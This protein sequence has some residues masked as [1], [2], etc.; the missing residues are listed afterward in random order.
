MTRSADGTPACRRISAEKAAF[1]IPRTILAPSCRD[2]EIVLQRIAHHFGER[3]VG[4]LVWPPATDQ[5]R[6]S[7]TPLLS[8]RLGEA[9]EGQRSHRVPLAASGVAPKDDNRAGRRIGGQ[10][11]YGFDKTRGA[12]E[13]VF[14]YE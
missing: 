6:Q 5:H 3:I 2:P 4:L 14:G 8:R 13:Q 12:V 11:R 9:L 1:S 7:E 10:P